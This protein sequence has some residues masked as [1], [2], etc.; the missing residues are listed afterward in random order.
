MSIDP[1]NFSGLSALLK[2]AQRDPYSADYESGITSLYDRQFNKGRSL[3]QSGPAN[4]R[5][6]TARQGFE[7]GEVDAQNSMNRFREIRGQQDREAGVVQQAIQTMNAI[8]GMR[9]GSQMQAQGQNMSGE[10]GRKG[11]SLSAAGQLTSRRQANAG[12]LALAAEMLGRPK[13][14]TTDSL[15]GRGSQSASSSN[16]GTGA[17]CCFIFLEALNGI[18]PTYVRQGRDEFNT[19]N[20]R[21]GYV[22]MSTWLVPAMRRWGLILS[23]VNL[24]IIKPFL[25]V[26]NW[27]YNKKH[28]ILGPVLKPYCWA[29]FWIWSF[30]GVIYGNDN[31]SELVG[32]TNSSSV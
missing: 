19:P 11:A 8:E 5:G 30:L 18:L 25:I 21:S 3:A 29:W 7:L 1:A 17:S 2:M 12:N 31:K 23:L 26:G 22:W 6:G 20:R 14:T 10:L 15:S 13:Q 24:F 32:Y 9:R 27:H 4:V 28:K 16:W